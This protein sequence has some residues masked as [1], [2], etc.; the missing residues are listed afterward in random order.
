MI[1]PVILFAPLEVDEEDMADSY[2]DI[3]RYI[4]ALL[5]TSGVVSLGVN[6]KDTVKFASTGAAIAEGSALSVHDESDSDYQN[7]SGFDAMAVIVLNGNDTGGATRHVKIW[8][9][10]T[11]D[12]ITA[13]T[14][15]FETGDSDNN[16]FD[17]NLDRLTTPPCRIQDNHF[18][19]VENIDDS[20]AGTNNVNV[21]GV[22]ETSEASTVIVERGE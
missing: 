21:I 3:K 9:A 7:L 18:I 11:T 6:D 4:G 5:N 15:V 20:R 10:P 1:G 8:S 2:L 16:Y 19:V 22:V 17:A 13:A 12:S 14:L